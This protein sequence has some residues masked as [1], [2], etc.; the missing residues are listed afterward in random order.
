VERLT[1]RIRLLA[2]VLNGPGPN[3]R[4]LE[5]AVAGLTRVA[6]TRATADLLEQFMTAL[7][8][9]SDWLHADIAPERTA[10]AAVYEN[11]CIVLRDLFGPL[12]LRLPVMDDLVGRREPGPQDV[13]LLKQR[14]GDERHLIYLFD[15][16][17]GPG[18]FR[19]LRDDPLLLPAPEGPWSAGPYVARI[20]AS[21]PDDVRA[22][23]ARL[24][25]DLNARQVGDALRIARIVKVDVTDTVLRLARP[26]F[27][28]FQVDVLLREMSPEERETRTA[29]AHPAIA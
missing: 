3:E 9:V 19:A 16:A 6:P 22:R 17:E 11:T 5:Q 27:E 20:A 13:E 26:H 8:E 21:D 29:L 10:V 18:W 23:L 1:E 2:E 4:R 28:L 12:S 15:R 24:P 14:L 25:G 7:D